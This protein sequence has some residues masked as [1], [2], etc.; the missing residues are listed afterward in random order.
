MATSEEGV[1]SDEGA[2]A[3]AG[4][5][6]EETA[7]DDID[8]T[9]ASSSE[10]GACMDDGA[11]V[12]AKDRIVERSIGKVRLSSSLTAMHTVR[13]PCSDPAMAV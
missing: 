11:G 3:V 9:R 12:R 6:A 10:G 4:A 1:P 13:V 5:P 7:T 2:Q 8:C